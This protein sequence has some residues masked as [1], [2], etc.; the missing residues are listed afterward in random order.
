LLTRSRPLPG[1]L[2]VGVSD[3]GGSSEL[4][5]EFVVAACPSPDGLAREGTQT[6]D[7]YYLAPGVPLVVG[8]TSV[9]RGK[10]RAGSSACR[11]LCMRTL[12]FP[13]E[14]PGPPFYR[15]KERVQMYNG[16]CSNALTCQVE[17]CLSPMYM[18]TWLSGES[19]S[20]VCMIVWPSEKR[21][22][23]VGAQ[24]AVRQGSC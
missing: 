4:T 1:A 9:A 14:G 20:P 17:K 16:E 13:R 15:C 5:S 10:K 11:P 19:L 6:N 3:P 23:P 8:V 2:T 21:L 24:L 12:L 22:S 7:L 18:P